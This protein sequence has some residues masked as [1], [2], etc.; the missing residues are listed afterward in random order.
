MKVN[1]G[2]LIPISTID[3]H[4]KSSVVLF[5]RSCPY[6]C[7]YC[8]NFEILSDPDM[9]D[10]KELEKK[11]DAS[12]L[13]VSSVVLSG[14][15][16]LVQKKAIM[17]LAAYAKKKGLLVGIHTNGYY[18]DVVEELID[19][20]IVDKFFIDVKAPLDDVA[21]YGKAIGYGVYDVVPDPVSV[22]E[23]IRATISIVT[24]KAI[25]Y[26]LRT[27][28]IRGFIGDSNDVGDIA[29]SVSQYL[30]RSGAPYVLQQGLPA[31]AMDET[32]RDVVPFT[33]A[34]M[35]EIAENAHKYIDN[36]WIRTK[37]KGNEKVNFESN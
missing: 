33:R 30:L 23:N 8:Q 9:V 28:L 34:E 31:H 32:L 29:S 20:E 13:F 15:E 3:W 25:D 35:L 26:E 7:P 21:M 14:G 16:P 5:L 36:I 2:E 4:G 1:F 18:P 22:I 6:R 17:H 11:I 19:S 24:E 37:E 10:V 27:T 12:S